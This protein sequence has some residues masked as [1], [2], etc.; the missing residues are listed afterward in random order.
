MSRPRITQEQAI[1]RY[2][3][4]ENYEAHLVKMLLWHKAHAEEQK[5]YRWKNR[6]RERARSRKWRADHPEQVAQ[7]KANHKRRRQIDKRFAES[8]NIR[9]R[10]RYLA[11]KL[12]IDRTGCELHHYTEPI[13]LGNFIV[14]SREKHR[15]LHSCFGG[16]N[17]NID[18]KVIKDVLPILGKV[19]L[20][21]DGKLTSWEVLGD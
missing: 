13:T 3:S 5:D 20:V 4:L 21:K 7:I 8:L 2:G 18:L 9:T 1:E 14:I 11:D 15:W 12:G 10:S 16:T 17:R 6:D 19:V